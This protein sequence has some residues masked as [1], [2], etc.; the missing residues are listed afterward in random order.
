MA[1]S[2]SDELKVFNINKEEKLKEHIQ[3][4]PI[5][6]EVFNFNEYKFG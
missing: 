6:K 2:R 5:K 3:I 1:S 4:S